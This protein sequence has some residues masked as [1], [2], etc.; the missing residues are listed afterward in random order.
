[1]VPKS[2]SDCGQARVDGDAA[3]RTREAAKS[4]AR[5]S[6]NILAWGSADVLLDALLAGEPL[7][8]STTPA[9]IMPE[10]VRR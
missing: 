8:S 6:P 9:L 10:G 7:L 3:F 1:V 4:A 5:D 2:R